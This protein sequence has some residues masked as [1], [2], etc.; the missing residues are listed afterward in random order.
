MDKQ[1]QHEM[2]TG[3]P[4]LGLRVHSDNLL[5]CY[6]YLLAPTTPII[7]HTTPVPKS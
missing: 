1:M 7:S 4:N 5:I 6:V 2:E 3:I